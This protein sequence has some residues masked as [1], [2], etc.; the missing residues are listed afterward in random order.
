[1][2]IL[3]LPD[4]KTLENP[5]DDINGKPCVQKPFCRPESY[6]TLREIY[7]AKQSI[8]QAAKEVDIN[9]M[10]IKWI[11]KYSQPEGYCPGWVINHPFEQFIQEEMKDGK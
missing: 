6:C 7:Q 2:K 5:C 1:M 3:I 11:S 4:D 10:A 9:V 8:L